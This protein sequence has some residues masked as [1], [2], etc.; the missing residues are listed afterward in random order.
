MQ[1]EEILKEVF[2][3]FKNGDVQFI[4]AIKCLDQGIDLPL[5]D[6]AI[7]L[8]SSR[9]PREYIQRRGRILR[10]YENKEFSIVHD[11]IVLPYLIKTLE[12]D[13]K[14]L[15]IFEA[16]IL[17]NQIER[18]RIFMDNSLNKPENDLKLL[19][20]GNIIVNYVGG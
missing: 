16:N 2:D 18:V 12:T 11:I 19:V 7:I 3:S 1:A 14:R 4:V 13:N 20:Y 10:L 6:S 9:N 17:K 15:Q 5:C 8:T